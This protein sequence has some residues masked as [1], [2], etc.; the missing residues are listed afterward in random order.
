MTVI[1][2]LPM[3]HGGDPGFDA[4][5]AWDLAVEPDYDALPEP[6]AKAL[7]GPRTGAM[8]AMW[9]PLEEAERLAV[10]GGEAAA[11][12]HVTL[13]Y[14][15][16][17]V[18]VDGDAVLEAVRAAAVR[19]KEPLVASVT[20]VARFTA[21]DDGVPEVLLVNTPGL[22][23]LRARLVE[24]LA[25]R[26]VEV[27][28]RFDFMPHATLRYLAEDDEA[29]DFPPPNPP[30]VEWDVTE[31]VVALGDERTRVSLGDGFVLEE[32]LLRR[33]RTPEGARRFGL[34]IGAVIVADTPGLPDL[35]PAGE[36]AQAKKEVPSIQELIEQGW[37]P[38]KA[39]KEHK[40]LH[41]NRTVQ[42]I[43]ARQKA[44][45]AGGLLKELDA[46]QKVTPKPGPDVPAAVAADLLLK[47][48]QDPNPKA[49]YD[50]GTTKTDAPG[51][52]W[53]RSGA[54][55]ARAVRHDTHDDPKAP[56]TLAEAIPVLGL[57]VGGG[58]KVH[59]GFAV[60]RGGV[61]YLVEME[62]QDL[63]G[64]GDDGQLSEERFAEVYRPRLESAMTSYRRVLDG[65]PGDQ[66]LTAAMQGVAILHGANPADQMWAQKYSVAGFESKA[67]GGLGGNYWWKGNLP[68]PASIAH[69]FGHVVDSHN[70]NG[71]GSSWLSKAAKGPQ[72]GGL[73]WRQAQ[74]S[75]RRASD[76]AFL[77][78]GG[79]VW[80]RPGGHPITVG[81]DAVSAYGEHSA[82]E[83]FAES[84]R[85]YL[86]DRREAK[87]GFMSAV[88]TDGSH[89]PVG[90]TT[91]KMEVR[92]TDLFPE[93]ARFLD[94]VFGHESNFDTPYRAWQ[95]KRAGDAAYAFAKG[96][97]D[98][99]IK[100]LMDGYGLSA[101]EAA[102]I[103]ADAVQRAAAD[104]AAE[105]AAAREAQKLEFAGAL[106]AF[107]ADELDRLVG[108]DLAGIDVDLDELYQYGDN[109]KEE[110]PDEVVGLV[111]NVSDDD[112]S[113]AKA[114]EDVANVEA[115]VDEVVAEKKA[116][117]LNDQHEALEYA[118]KV[119]A[120]FAEWIDDT[121]GE[122]G[123]T[124]YDLDKL[125]DAHYTS[126]A[127]MVSP[128]AL[129]AVGAP[130]EA[131]NKALDDYGRLFRTAAAQKRSDI[132]AKD[133][134]A[135]AI[136]FAA[137]LKTAFAAWL[138]D[139][140]G[141]E[142]TDA[143][144]DDAMGAAINASGAGVNDG[145]VA[146]GEI[147]YEVL[148]QAIGDDLASSLVSSDPDGTYA[149]FVNLAYL[150]DEAAEEKKAAVAK[151][152]ATAAKL[153]AE[154]EL[155][156]ATA[157][158][159]VFQASVADYAKLPQ[160]TAKK[161]RK[162]KAA[163]KF[164]A[165]KGGATPEAA[166][167]AADEYELNALA[168]ALEEL[169]LEG[170]TTVLDTTITSDGGVASN[171]KMRAKIK[172]GTNGKSKQWLK[173]AGVAAHAKSKTY[174]PGSYGGSGYGSAGRAKDYL[175]LEL[176]SR[177]N[178]PEGWETFRAYRAKPQPGNGTGYH[179][180]A[181]ALPAFDELD[182]DTRLR[183]IY[184]DVNRR[185][186]NW[187][188]TSG[189]SSVSALAMQHAVKDEFGLS[190]DWG[191]RFLTQGASFNSSKE[192]L[193]KRVTEEYAHVGPWYRMV[194]RTMYEH[195][196]AELAAAGITELGL[197]RGMNGMSWEVGSDVRPAL[198]PANSWSTSKA[199][200]KRF[201]MKVL[202]AT[203]PASRILGS[204]RTGFGCLNEEE[205]VVLDSDGLAHVTS[206][207]KYY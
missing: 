57:T 163:V 87:L 55:W 197:H 71:A 167:L 22:G 103:K 36:S 182:E 33:V 14:L 194:V 141:D 100:D 67:T 118:G 108:D 35:L 89:A 50:W 171:E 41:H 6:G 181:E 32:K 64:L 199:I 154:A 130:S 164:Y 38:E 73:T 168:A 76:R 170:G 88:A 26:G 114:M 134:E 47:G 127:S 43:R 190:A 45:K 109:L 198:Q 13:A 4:E 121:L 40:R 192:E 148:T 97:E 107:L 19:Q 161:I 106:K 39:V 147:E 56:V 24:E 92:F 125:V 111:M 193:L 61:T 151:K 58:Y 175:I 15:G 145:E 5:A 172:A 174:T 20:G 17:A 51:A 60:R 207:S 155:Q 52:V 62:D 183:R 129:A 195:T 30:D 91:T 137:A 206:K 86:K 81:Q 23:A 74:L 11:E 82:Q 84:V 132:L 131:S 3:D 191:A 94:A 139:T 79:L 116:R 177:L 188:S 126:Y 165:K 136:E 112:E 150:L 49:L 63:L 160:D 70:V 21:G 98:P 158:A 85:L 149:T 201:G 53:D 162:K 123:Q 8:V 128:E 203:I 68:D 113:T 200:A 117:L 189:D 96:G 159:A 153:A 31:L 102:E 48:Q 37:D 44:E 25:V 12:M 124:L 18:D 146:D 59:R 205:F 156:Q 66:G 140:L 157:D 184:D 29:L 7:H 186:A 187:A 169:G 173:Q 138:D 122:D 119:Q 105:L 99:T 46:K 95:K 77:A 42:L 101:A 185:I 133:R 180:D 204:A 143:E 80:T 176:S 72:P 16:K 2:P 135:K 202:S 110:L 179:I 144:I 196:Q 34:P 69:E 28:T 27:P 115:L 83:D 104:R 75:D 142:P 93:R 78:G 10:P 1:L 54:A 120:A 9:V 65:V 152:Q 90:S 178:T 166:Q